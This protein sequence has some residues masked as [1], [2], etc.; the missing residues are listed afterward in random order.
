MNRVYW[1]NHCLRKAAHASKRDARRAV[2]KL[3]SKGVRKPGSLT[4]Y[5]CRRCG[6]WHVGHI[7]HRARARRRSKAS[8]H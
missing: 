8:R 1:A 3:R 6:C 5:M 7:D 4:I 2:A